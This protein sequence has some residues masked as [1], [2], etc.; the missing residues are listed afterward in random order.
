[1]ENISYKF[2]PQQLPYSQKGKKW[3][4]QCV[5]F[6]CNHTFLAS[7]VNRKSVLHKQLNYN[8]LDGIL[9]MNDV[10][11]ILNPMGIKDDLIPKKIQHYPIINSKL[12]VLSGEESKRLFDYK[13]VVADPNSITEAS[14]AKKQELLQE[15][16]S[17]IESTSSSEEELTQRL[18]ELSK[19]YTYT[20]QDI[21][22]VRA[23]RLLKHYSTENNFANMF[24]AGFTD[25]EAVG[26][27]LYQC[28]IVGGA[29][30]LERLDPRQV[31]VVR[32]SH[33][34]KIEDADMIIIESYWSPG[35]IIDYYYDVLTP[36][37]RKYI[38]E[39]CDSSVTGTDTDEMGNL[40]EK[41]GFVYVGD[42]R[43]NDKQVLNALFE[44]P[45]SYNIHSVYDFDGNIRV[46]RVYWKSRR[47]IKKVTSYD[48]VTGEEVVNFRTE[49]YVINKDLGEK[50]EIFWV[51]EAW[52][53]TKI[54][55]N[56]YVNIR[57]RPVQYNTISNP[58]RCHFGIIGSLYTT[59]DSAPYSMVDRMKPFN[60][61]YDVTHDRLNRALAKNY[62]KILEMDLSLVPDGWEVD[63]WLYF[64]RKDGIAVKNSFNEGKGP[65]SGKPA[66]GLNNASKGVIDL[67]T[68]NTIQQYI[69]ILEFLKIEM[70]EVVG[71]SKQREG[72]ISNRETVGG[73]ERATLQS[74]HITEWIF[75]THEDIK[76]RVLEAFIETAKV[77][78]K[79][80]KEIFQYILPDAAQQMVEIDGDEFAESDY[81]L[82]VDNSQQTQELA[83]RMD[84]YIQAALQNQQINF[85]TAL[86]MFASCSL[87][88]KMRMVENNEKELQQRAQ[89][90][91]EQEFQV[92][93]QE[94]QAKAQAEQ[95]KLD[96]Q[97]TLNERD[98]D[99][100]LT[101]AMLQAESQN[102][103][104]N[105]EPDSNL[106]REQLLEKMREFD[107]RL[108]F[109][110][111]NAKED[112]KLK[113]EQIH[114][115]TTQ[116]K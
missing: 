52:E 70:T 77:A 95:R 69:N 94:I 61:L 8:L 104:D 103:E 20:W 115:K 108:A 41:N 90:M 24:N 45:D 105:T 93:Q 56:I 6:A 40:H 96:M 36:A 55:E 4:K 79:G 73:V 80:K 67:D 31:T 89:Q 91:Q 22:E 14:D 116:K 76:K 30:V 16:Q 7:G 107:E 33:S 49:N 72:Q 2:P 84:T 62:G 110:K 102:Q 37:D 13:V 106:S 63:K 50:E 74:S 48:L 21:R 65:F 32:S 23:N 60:Y 35:K 47:K 9:D 38:E 92:R 10:E 98:N 53:G 58:S 44:T 82:I 88:E 64:I 109:D 15:L 99:T 17:L 3:R 11:L 111:E 27:E 42:T 114:S 46:V 75:N 86:K 34:N 101:I 29:P 19:Y 12:D 68:G 26:E 39:L 66:G 1:M 81:N 112:R 71:I 59:R 87:A 25:A 97:N 18:E 51:N 83:Q 57:P 113:R 43:L 85:S 78:L 100:K 28:D 5:D 54:G